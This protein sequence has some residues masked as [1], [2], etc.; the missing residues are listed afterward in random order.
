M[1]FLNFLEAGNKQKA[2]LLAGY[3][4]VSLIIKRIFIR[5]L[6]FMFFFQVWH[7]RQIRWESRR[8]D[9]K[10]GQGAFRRPAWSAPPHRHHNEPQR[11]SGELSI[12]NFDVTLVKVTRWLFSGHFKVLSFNHPKRAIFCKLVGKLVWAYIKLNT[13]KRKKHIE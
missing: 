13:H 8:G 1:R 2:F 9:E 4:F 3:D 10:F 7:P 6:F 12:S 5:T 11:A